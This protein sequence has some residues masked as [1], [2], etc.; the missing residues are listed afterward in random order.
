MLYPPILD[1]SLP[2]FLISESLNVYFN[3]SN[4]SKLSE[5]KHY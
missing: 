4:I 5:L 3:L 2:P 1:K